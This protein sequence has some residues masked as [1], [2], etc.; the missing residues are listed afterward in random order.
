[1]RGEQYL[2]KREQFGLV[3]TGGSSHVCRTVVIKALPNGLEFSRY[4]LT[5][6]KRVGNAVKRNRVKRLLREIVRQVSLK[7]GW[8]IIIIARPPAAK[9]GFT[10]LGKSVVDVLSR[11]GVLLGEYE[12]NCPGAN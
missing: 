11:A 12:E 8:D 6:S 3:Y 2:T 4:G 1:V 7:P 10:G 5:V 9:T